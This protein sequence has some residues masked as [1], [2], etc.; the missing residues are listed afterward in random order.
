[1]FS[2]SLFLSGWTRQTDP[3]DKTGLREEETLSC[4]R[5]TY[6]LGNIHTGAT[7]C[8]R[9]A[10]ITEITKGFIN[11]HSQIML[12]LLSQNQINSW[13]WTCYF[14]GIIGDSINRC[15]QNTKI[16]LKLLLLVT[17]RQISQ[18]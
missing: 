12:E 4:L 14:Y 1:M 9:D 13:W 2:P 5:I 3:S 7:V 6:R 15:T 8:A 16:K 11:S 10:Q 18:M 17:N